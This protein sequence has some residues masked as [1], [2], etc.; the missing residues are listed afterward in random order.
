MRRSQQSVRRISRDPDRAQSTTIL[1]N[2][3]ADVHARD[4]RRRPT[5]TLRPAVDV[6]DLHQRV[7]Q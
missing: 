4:A 5:T 1:V 2:D 7:S 6:V 3:P